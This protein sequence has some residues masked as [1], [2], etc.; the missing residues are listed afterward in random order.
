MT[1]TEGRKAPKARKPRANPTAGADAQA[2]VRHMIEGAGYSLPGI[3]LAIE[4]DTA[5]I[6]NWRRGAHSI[7]PRK[8]VK[9]VAAIDRRRATLLA[10]K[11]IREPRTARELAALDAARAALETDAERAHVAE[12]V[13]RWTSQRAPAAPVETKSMTT[14]VTT[15]IDPFELI[16]RAD[17]AQTELPF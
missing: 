12:L 8:L 15:Q 14:S 3:A 16:E 2:A 11:N 1:N 4:S 9:L 17:P 13:E 7:S 5:T 10:R 6:R